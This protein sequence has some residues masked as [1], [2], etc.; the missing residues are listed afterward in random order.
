MY[1]YI[2]YWGFKKNI[3]EWQLGVCN[4]L[5][6]GIVKGDIYR[7]TKVEVKL[8][9]EQYQK[10]DEIIKKSIREGKK[11]YLDRLVKET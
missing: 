2:Y 6:A 5:T 8:L 1:L 11:K 3:V 4:S 10:V 9:Q 7:E